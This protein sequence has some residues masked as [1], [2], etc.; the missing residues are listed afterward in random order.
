MNID[1]EEILN[2][3]SLLKMPQG[4]NWQAGCLSPL[5]RQSSPSGQL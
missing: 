2:S 5:H 4:M 1:L 3:I